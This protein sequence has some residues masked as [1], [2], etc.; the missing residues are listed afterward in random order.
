M[1]HRV[2]H[3]LLFE[4]ADVLPVHHPGT[5]LD[6]APMNTCRAAQRRLTRSSP[7]APRMRLVRSATPA[8]HLRLPPEPA[9]ISHPSRTADARPATEHN[10]TFTCPPTSPAPPPQTH[11]PP[12]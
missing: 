2:L 11:I 8:M 7:R 1:I 6:A 3:G 10:T 9:R 5:D 12:G 4:G